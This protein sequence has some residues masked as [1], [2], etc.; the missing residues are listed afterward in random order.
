MTGCAVLILSGGSGD[1]FSAKI[2][3]QYFKLGDKTIIRHAIDA[4]LEHPGIDVIRVVRRPQDKNLYEESVTGISILGPTDGGKTRQ[5]S[6]RL[7]LESLQDIKP[8]WVLIHDA[9]RPFP[10]KNL[11]TRA[12]SGLT[13]SHAVV[14]GLPLLDTIKE[15]E[16]D[17]KTIKKTIDRKKLWRAQTPQAFHYKTILNAHR[18]TIQEEVTD[19]AALAE[20]NGITVTIVDGDNDNIKI[21]TPEDI[22]QAKKMLNFSDT[23]THV[24]TGFD[25]HRFGPGN[26]V[27]LCGIKINHEQGLEGHSDA[28]VP[29]H[30]LTD[31]ILGA[32]S[33]GDIGSHFPPSDEK[34]RGAPS[35][36]FLRHATKLVENLKGKILNVDVTIICESPKISPHRESMQKNISE[37]IGISLSSVSVKATTTEQLG[38][39]GR[40]EGIVAQAIT[41]ILLPISKD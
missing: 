17:R 29:M 36:H 2:P 7:G 21:T 18:T 13:T 14:P 31:A 5:E 11:I 19:D 25:A 4:F 20:K 15:L 16:D 8:K 28:D 39:T 6:V 23:V 12:L 24:G 35:D 37:V 9:A 30:A 34:W 3:K 33:A 27:L 26:H 32:I 22:E 10:N 41:S 38:F 40:R 1:R